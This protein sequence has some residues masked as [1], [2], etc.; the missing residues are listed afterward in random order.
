[1]ISKVTQDLGEN[2]TTCILVFS[3]E[4]VIGM[5][6]VVLNWIFMGDSKMEKET[7]GT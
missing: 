1:M 6:R 4:N 5:T 3:F 2:Y 7:T